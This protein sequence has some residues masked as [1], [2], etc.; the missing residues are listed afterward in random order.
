MT[1]PGW[2]D[3]GW[4]MP[5]NVRA[6][7]ATRLW[8]GHSVGPYGSANFGDHVGDDAVAV[9]ANRADLRR[10]LR[11]PADPV[12]LK[13]VHGCA[14]W[15]NT[16]DTADAA[17]TRDEG[18]VLAI[19]TADCLPILVSD[20]H[21]REIAAIHAGWRGLADG[22]IEATLDRMQSPREQLVAWIGP[23][24]GPTAFEVGDD[25]RDA[26]LLGTNRADRKDRAAAF[27]PRRIG[28][29]PVHGKWWCDL[30][31]LARSRLSRAGVGVVASS[32][33]CSYSE[34]ER[35]YSHRR[36][37]ITGRMASLIWIEP[38]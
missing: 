24:I 2:I 8:P 16:G 36:D 22:V 28:L 1:A 38:A 31:M 15:P 6:G 17:V 30:P 33:F 26:M 37:R 25:V 23:G 14:V 34:P 32:G 13:Q 9:A 4:P 7:T 29:D 20:P 11:L 21:G 10:Q 19:L 35:F 5:D 27:V 18:V 12:W 3:A